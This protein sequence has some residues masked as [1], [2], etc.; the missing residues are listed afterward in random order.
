M[1]A[2]HGGARRGGRGGRPEETEEIAETEEETAGDNTARRK[3]RSADGEAGQEAI[4][5]GQA[6]DT[7]HGSAG[8]AVRK[9]R[10]GTQEDTAS[11]DESAQEAM[12]SSSSGPYRASNFSVHPRLDVVT[13]TDPKRHR[14]IELGRNK[15]SGT[16][17]GR[18]RKLYWQSPGKRALRARRSVPGSME[19]REMRYTG[20]KTEAPGDVRK[21]EEKYVYKK[22]GNE[23]KN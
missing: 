19:R 2:P 10:K 7:V 15:P 4:A 23:E 8:D 16:S 6:G 11:D 12:C 9:V 5:G 3:Q 22:K 17:C 18:R 21:K 13:G 1:S 20:S 14:P